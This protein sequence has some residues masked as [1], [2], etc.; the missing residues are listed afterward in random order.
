MSMVIKRSFQ[1]LIV[2]ADITPGIAQAK[3]DISGTKL[4]PFNPSGRMMRSIINTTR[5]KYPVSS[6]IPMKKE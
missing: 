3:L 1:L 6:K 2:R 4:F 5:D